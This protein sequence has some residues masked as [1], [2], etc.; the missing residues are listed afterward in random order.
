VLASPPRVCC[1]FSRKRSQKASR[2]S[3]PS[4]WFDAAASFPQSRPTDTAGA[5]AARRA[6]PRPTTTAAPACSCSRRHS[7]RAAAV[8]HGRPQQRRHRIELLGLTENR[9]QREV[10]GRSGQAAVDGPGAGLGESGHDGA[11]DG[12]SETGPHVGFLFARRGKVGL[13]EKTDR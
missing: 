10:A 4:A 7:R 8:Q 3:T 11:C 12:K 6:F 5:G 9:R 13:L 2:P 1:F